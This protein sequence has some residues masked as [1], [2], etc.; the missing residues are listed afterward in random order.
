MP[1]EQ[2]HTCRPLLVLADTCFSPSALPT[3]SRSCDG[4]R[5]QNVTTRTTPRIV[6]KLRSLNGTGPRPMSYVGNSPGCCKA[7]ILWWISER[8]SQAVQAPLRLGP[9]WVRATT[10]EHGHG[11]S[12]TVAH[13][14]EEPQVAGP[15]AQAAWMMQTRG[16]DGGPEGRSS[17]LLGYPTAARATRRRDAAEVAVRVAES[18]RAQPA[19]WTR[20]AVVSGHVAGSGPSTLKTVAPTPPTRTATP[21]PP[22]G[23][24]DSR[25][26]RCPGM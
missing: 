6:P 16:S 4:G 13:G 24:T 10:V 26:I 22:A 11:R 20:P 15:L 8:W 18:S 21:A 3:C 23:A 7:D 25:W 19:P 17:S 9:R 5:D 2:Q 12:P 14:S 1:S